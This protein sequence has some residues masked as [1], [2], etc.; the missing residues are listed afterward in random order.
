MA[1]STVPCAVLEGALYHSKCALTFNGGKYV[2]EM[3]NE[4]NK[5]T[6]Q[7]YGEE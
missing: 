5:A 6:E 3:L 7:E 2:T 1:F 4:S